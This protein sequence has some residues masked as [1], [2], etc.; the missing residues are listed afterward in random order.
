MPFYF[1]D[2]TAASSF[3]KNAEPCLI[4]VFE[5]RGEPVI[6][7]RVMHKHDDCLEIVLIRGGSGQYL[8]D[9]RMY[10]AGRG[11]LLVYNA[12]VI[13]DENTSL[14]ETLQIYY[15]R[16]NRVQIRGLPPNHLL[17]SGEAPLV[18]CGDQ[19]PEIE[20]LF[21]AMIRQ[22]ALKSPQSMEIAQR[23]LPVL[24]L[25]VRRL[26]R[27]Q[28]PEVPWSEPELGLKIK[29]YLDSH[30]AE[31]L[32]LAAIA[33]VF[34][35]NPYYLAHLF[36]EQTGYPPM[37]DLIRRRIGEAQSLLIHSS[38]TVRD[39]AMAV[40]FNNLNHF[41]SS[42]LKLTGMTPGRYRKQWLEGNT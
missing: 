29:T 8:V 4:S 15:C 23:L 17:P 6:M 13:H 5:T 40:G 33:D 22:A 12:G 39:I 34:H 14:T 42:F 7:P 19:W 9:G 25:S 30:Y 11:D 38:L 21:A 32:T 26:A 41:H 35:I 37:Q 3:E 31:D 16:A 10:Q 28:P 24:L 18:P 20:G 2:K 27:Q 36:K 1:I